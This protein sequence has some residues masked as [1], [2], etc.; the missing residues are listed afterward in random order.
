MRHFSG[1][2]IVR[3][4]P[5]NNSRK[6]VTAFAASKS[7]RE[8]KENES[9]KKSVGKKAR[10]E[11]VVSSENNSNRNLLVSERGKV[12]RVEFDVDKVITN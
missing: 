8:E 5:S 6:P 4:F 10:M 12:K 2:L 9:R 3:R 11:D 1:F 7:R